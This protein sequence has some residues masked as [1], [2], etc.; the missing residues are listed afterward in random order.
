GFQFLPVFFDAC[1][2]SSTNGFQTTS[3]TIR[4]RPA[5]QVS[6]PGPAIGPS[7]RFP[8]G[9]SLAKGNKSKFNIKGEHKG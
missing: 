5:P 1:R 6:S 2:L 8:A 9:F 4:A 7:S 3:H